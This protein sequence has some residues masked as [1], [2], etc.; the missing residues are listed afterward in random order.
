MIK[1]LRVTVDGNTYDVTVELPDDASAPASAA[2]PVSAPVA[3]AAPASPPIAPAASTPPP[4]PAPTASP[5]GAAQAGDVP[6]P[7]AGRVTAV[8][9]KV[10]QEVKEGD[11]LLTLEA[12]K[13]NTF[14]FAPKA[15]K[16]LELKVTVGD[17]VEEGQAL[18][19]IQ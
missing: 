7:L 4:L 17:A 19:R 14:V 15:G 11:H 6:S 16:A 13:M 10:G 3:P 5:A 1:K 9:V 2:D 12:M 8:V 18:A